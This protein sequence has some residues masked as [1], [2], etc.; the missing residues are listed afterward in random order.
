VVSCERPFVRRGE[1]IAKRAAPSRPAYGFRL[2]VQESVE[3]EIETI[4]KFQPSGR[5]L[6]LHFG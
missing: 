5:L 6:I 4:G 1:A 3:H 2:P